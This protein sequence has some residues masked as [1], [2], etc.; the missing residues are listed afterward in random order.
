MYFTE[1]CRIHVIE[2]NFQSDSTTEE[3]Q[4]TYAKYILQP[5]PPTKN[6][7]DLEEY[8]IFENYFV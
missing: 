7:E 3:K 5:P 4:G 6:H 1:T 8:F 2:W